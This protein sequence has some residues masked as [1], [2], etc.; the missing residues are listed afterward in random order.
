[1]DSIYCK[2][3]KEQYYAVYIPSSYDDSE[4]W[5]IIYFFEPAARAKLPL[6]L[7]K[8]LAEKYGLLLAC[9][10]N[11]RNGP[12]VINEKAYQN[13]SEDVNIRLKL[14]AKRQFTSGFSG[15]GRFSQLVA[16]NDSSITGVI[17]VAGPR[18]DGA[19]FDAQTYA[20]PYVGIVGNQ[21]MNYLEH[22]RF[23][24]TLDELGVKNELIIY[25]AA[26]QWPPKE[27]YDQ[28]I[29]WHL[30][31]LE[32]NIKKNQST[33]LNSYMNLRT[34]YLDTTQAMSNVEK[35]KSYQAIL[36]N[37]K[38]INNSIINEKILAIESEKK[39]DKAIKQEEKILQNEEEEQIA[40]VKAL[41]EFRSYF[42][43]PG[44]DPD[45]GQYSLRWWKSEIGQIS[46]KVSLDNSKGLSAARL[47]DFLRGQVHNQVQGAKAFNNVELIL[48]MHELNLYLYPNSIWFLWNQAIYC[49][50]YNQKD[51]A[52]SY[53][54]KAKKINDEL[55]LKI[56]QYPMFN[57]LRDQYTYLYE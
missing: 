33:K 29:Q 14:D 35:Q 27:I 47:I 21:D 15:G 40:L 54:K 44:F 38:D 31:L 9:S 41:N 34:Q 11:S 30:G 42:F 5:P 12:I 4:S 39:L 32:Y 13:M 52:I 3:D 57:G 48:S 8:D 28:A 55:L 10:Y 37:F 26:H 6:R 46:N 24:Q 50:Q 1:M 19:L 53:L 45:S 16:Q 7:Y 20:T 22:T 49:A 2:N 23:Q 56:Q 17:A 36:K 43:R 18:G 25:H 51:K